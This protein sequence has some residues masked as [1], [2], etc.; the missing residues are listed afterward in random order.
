MALSA[1]L[2]RLAT[3]CIRSAASQTSIISKALLTR[4]LV[5]RCSAL[6]LLHSS[7][8]SLLHSV[9]EKAK[10]IIELLN[11]NKR[12]RDEREKAR[13]PRDVSARMGTE[14]E[15]KIDE[16]LSNKN[17]GASST[18]LNEIAQITYD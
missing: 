9:R 2:R 16:A 1:L 15:R 17:W 18:L 12:I 5:V 7:A 6:H 13:R 3:T 4:A 14:T 10:Q 11:D 8:Y